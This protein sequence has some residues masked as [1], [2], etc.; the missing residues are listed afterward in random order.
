MKSIHCEQLSYY[1]YDKDRLQH[2]DIEAVAKL[3]RENKIWECGEGYL[4]GEPSFNQVRF[5]SPTSSFTAM[6]AAP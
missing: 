2:E 6:G 3:L 1:F 4:A 5:G